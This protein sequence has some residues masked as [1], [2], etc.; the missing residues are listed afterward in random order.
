MEGFLIFSISILTL[1]FVYVILCLALNIEC[2][3]AG[4]WDLGIVSYFGVGA[5]SYAIIV[6]PEAASYQHYLFGFES[7]PIYGIALAIVLGGVSAYLIGLP[8]LRLRREYFLI[9]TQN[10]FQF[11]SCHLIS[12]C[13]LF[14]Q[15]RSKYFVTSTDPSL[16]LT[17]ASNHSFLG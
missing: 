8:S 14:S 16:K 1:A 6:A 13:H 3:V 4:M 9:T 10:L 2:G 5:Y 17:A 15:G 7:N 11:H 12:P